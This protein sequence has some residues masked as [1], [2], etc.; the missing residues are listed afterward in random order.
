MNNTIYIYLKIN[1]N[2]V[3]VLFNNITGTIKIS[4]FLHPWKFKMGQK[5]NYVI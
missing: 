1:L 4:N 2:L 5:I 3:R